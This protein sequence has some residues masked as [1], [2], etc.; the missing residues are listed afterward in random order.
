[1]SSPEKPEPK[2]RNR[3][4]SPPAAEERKERQRSPPRH[5]KKSSGSGFKW[6]KNRDDNRDDDERRPRDF[7]GDS[8]RPKRYGGRDD[9]DRRDRRDWRD[10]R[11]D[12]RRD[13]NNRFDSRRGRDDTQDKFGDRKDREDRRDRDSRDFRDKRDGKASSQNERSKPKDIVPKPLA[14]NMTFIVVTVNDRLGTKARVPALPND[15]VG[16]FKKLVAAQIG[17]KPHEILLKRQGE[18]PFKDHITLADYGINNGV[19]IDLE[20]G[21]GD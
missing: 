1:M 6:K 12:D 8:Y 10:D 17:R 14:P 21:T 11:R 2:E 7:D 20:L 19:Q 3:S 5:P 18:N 15:T 13:D 9:R 4:A 16:D